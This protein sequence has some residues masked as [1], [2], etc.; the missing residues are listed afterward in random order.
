MIQND[1]NC[2]SNQNLRKAKLISKISVKHTLLAIPVGESRVIK[3]KDINCL[4]I[5]SSIRELKKEGY[6][7]SY[8]ESGR[9][10]SVVV[11]RKS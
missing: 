8:S 1:L 3:R 9:I 6:S 7:F 10:D 5:R 2:E 4:S 11:T